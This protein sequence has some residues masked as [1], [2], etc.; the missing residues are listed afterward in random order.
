MSSLGWPSTEGTEMSEAGSAWRTGQKS[1]SIILTQWREEECP[2]LFW[3]TE[4]GT[5]K[6]PCLVWSGVSEMCPREGITPELGLGG[7]TA[8]A[9]GRHVSQEAM[10]GMRPG[11]EGVQTV[12]SEMGLQHSW[13]NVQEAGRPQPGWCHCPGYRGG[14]PWPGLWRRMQSRDQV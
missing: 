11:G 4:R 9:G 8:K 7:E 1:K 14:G 13:D 10:R 6:L 2:K 5:T 12:D 3:D